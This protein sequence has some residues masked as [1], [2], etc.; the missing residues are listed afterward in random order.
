MCL[1]SNFETWWA[2]TNIKLLRTLLLG[3]LWS[4]A[5]VGTAAETAGQLRSSIFEWIGIRKEIKLTKRKKMCVRRGNSRTFLLPP[6]QCRDL[7]WNQLKWQYHL[8][9]TQRGL[10][11][12][13]IQSGPGSWGCETK[14]HSAF[15][16]LWQW[17]MR[18]PLNLTFHFQHHITALRNLERGWTG[19]L[20][21]SFISSV[22]FP[23]C[24]L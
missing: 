20:P 13:N 17:S 10:R 22:G 14:K 2:C 19:H 8:V 7:S 24:Q 18:L 1:I 9:V 5:G 4:Q 3:P 12:R 23:A 21:I 15:Y 11:H 6:K 16:K